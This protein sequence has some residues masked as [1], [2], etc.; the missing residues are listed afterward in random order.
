MAIFNSVLSPHIRKSMGGITFKNVGGYTIGSG[1]IVSNGS[2]T[3][4]QASQR[5]LFK[6]TQETFYPVLRSLSPLILHRKGLV[7][8]ISQLFSVLLTNPAVKAWNFHGWDDL[9]VTGRTL[10]NDTQNQANGALVGCEKHPTNLVDGDFSA[11][12]TFSLKESSYGT[13]GYYQI[14]RWTISKMPT[15]LAAALNQIA[16]EEYPTSASVTTIIIPLT[17][18]QVSSSDIVVMSYDEATSEENFTPADRGV[19]ARF[20]GDI[21]EV[22]FMRKVLNGPPSRVERPAHYYGMNGIPMLTIDGYRF[23]IT[24]NF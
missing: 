8:P 4:S 3:A 14:L 7:S 24:W 20:F 23:P 21:C 10:F 11:S 17:G 5:G 2:N 6:R 12:M 9:P 15:K 19:A 16:N 1:K 13:G 22:I 18:L